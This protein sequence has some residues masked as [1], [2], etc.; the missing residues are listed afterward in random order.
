MST[1]VILVLL[2]E[3]AAEEA[4]ALLIKSTQ[5]VTNV[6]DDINST[7]KPVVTDAEKASD[8]DAEEKQ[9]K[10]FKQL[11]E[12]N[13]DWLQMGPLKDAYGAFYRAPRRSEGTKSWIKAKRCGE[14]ETE[15][16]EPLS[17][18]EIAFNQNL[19]PALTSRGW[20]VEAVE[21]R[22]SP[23]SSLRYNYQ[24]NSVRI[25]FFCHAY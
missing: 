9:E 15:V 4:A 23:R 8:E 25:T 13:S 24:D 21:R 12:Q 2:K 6:G 17:P 16:E 20:K 10:C 19:L 7:I 11:L 1:S 14:D 22:N 3:L 18:L 5:D